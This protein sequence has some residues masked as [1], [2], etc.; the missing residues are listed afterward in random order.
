MS[1]FGSSG[2]R[3]GVGNAS[4]DGM[5]SIPKP[6]A[7]S[8]PGASMSWAEKRMTSKSWVLSSSGR[9][10]QTQADAAETIGAEKLVP[11]AKM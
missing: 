1:S 8:N 2:S 11:E 7:R 4:A 10:V 3:T 6:V 5:F 9:S